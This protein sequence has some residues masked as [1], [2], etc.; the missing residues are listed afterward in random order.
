MNVLCIINQDHQRQAIAVDHSSKFK[1][2]LSMI[3]SPLVGYNTE[4]G[5]KRQ[6]LIEKLPIAG[7]SNMKFLLEIEKKESKKLKSLQ[8]LE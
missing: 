7:I 1:A 3:N 4:N 2:I 5:A 8:K 6:K